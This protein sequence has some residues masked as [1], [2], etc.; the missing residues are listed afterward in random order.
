MS[1]LLCIHIRRNLN[2]LNYLCLLQACTLARRTAESFLKYVNRNLHTL[3]T[4]MKF[5]S[6][7]GHVKGILICFKVCEYLFCIG[8]EEMHLVS[9]TTQELGLKGLGIKPHWL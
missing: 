6:P 4:Q 9:G 1:Y 3:G 7:E 5:R 2:N 8:G